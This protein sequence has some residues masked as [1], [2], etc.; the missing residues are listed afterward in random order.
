[1]VLTR[2]FLA[3]TL[4]RDQRCVFAVIREKHR[5]RR[6]SGLNRMV[7][8]KESKGRAEF[9]SSECIYLRYVLTSMV[10]IWEDF[11]TF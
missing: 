5:K 8:R 10:A 3:E 1:M 11:K 6:R 4:K 9:M 2:S 7:C